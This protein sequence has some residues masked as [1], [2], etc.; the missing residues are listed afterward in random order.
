MKLLQIKHVTHIIIKCVCC[1]VS[2]NRHSEKSSILGLTSHCQVLVNS[3]LQIWSKVVHFSLDNANEVN[4]EMITL[5]LAEGRAAHLASTSASRFS[6]SHPVRRMLAS[7]KVRLEARLVSA[8]G[9]ITS[10]G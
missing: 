9:G 10:P 2:L 7:Q 3:W 4:R 8:E 5:W 1:P 6:L